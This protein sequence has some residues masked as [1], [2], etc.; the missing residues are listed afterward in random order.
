MGSARDAILRLVAPRS[1][2]Q[3]K[4]RKGP[5]RN[6]L[7]PHPW[8]HNGVERTNCEVQDGR[9]SAVLSLLPKMM[10]MLRSSSHY[11]QQHDG[12]RALQHP[13][14][15]RPTHY[16]HCLYHLYPSPPQPHC[17]YQ[18]VLVDRQIS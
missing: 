17:L 18:N 4:G 5:G 10:C 14:S 3:K 7:N 11:K 13:H 8:C 9:T 16:H 2:A 6:N 12:Q 15:R 1:S